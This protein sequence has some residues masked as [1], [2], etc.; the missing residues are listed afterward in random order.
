VK[1]QAELTQA[2]VLAKKQVCMKPLNFNS[3]GKPL[4]SGALHPLLKMR[5]AFIQIL[6]GMGFQ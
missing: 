4:A 1:P 5:S 6:V 3:L 2:D